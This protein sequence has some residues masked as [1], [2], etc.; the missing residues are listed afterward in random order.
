MHVL[1]IF[2]ISYGIMEVSTKFYDTTYSF[3]LD[4]IHTLYDMSQI[5]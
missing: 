1:A 3:L 4:D 2:T 5:H